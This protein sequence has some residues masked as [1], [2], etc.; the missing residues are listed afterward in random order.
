MEDVSGTVLRRNQNARNGQK[1]TQQW[2][3]DHE[4][5]TEETQ[6]PR[7]EKMSMDWFALLGINDSFGDIQVGDLFSFKAK[8]NKTK[9]SQSHLSFPDASR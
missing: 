2:H 9:A 5:D 7:T 6:I 3:M 4:K 8:Q 1:S